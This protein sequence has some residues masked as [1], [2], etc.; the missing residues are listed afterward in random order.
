MTRRKQDLIELTAR[1]PWWMSLLLGLG[2][3][4]FMAHIVPLSISGP[5]QRAIVP[6]LTVVGYLLAGACVMGAIAGFAIQLKQRW[7]Y[8]SQRSLDQIRKL[9]WADFEHLM[10]EAFRREGYAASLTDAGADGGVD[11]RLT[12]DGMLTLVQC[13]QWRTRRVGVGPV[14]ELAGVVAA[15]RA[16]EGIFVCSGSY[17]PEAQAFAERAGIRL[18]DGRGLASML[19]LESLDGEEAVERCPRCGNELVR[20]VAR[21]GR[22]AGEAFMGCSGFPGCRFTVSVR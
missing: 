5:F 18:V 10:A 2:L 15:A 11:I 19:R 6:A 9:G 8:E 16:K 21:R 22:S 17:T 20:R 3:Y 1:L 13:K 7:L 12:K 14:R 4:V